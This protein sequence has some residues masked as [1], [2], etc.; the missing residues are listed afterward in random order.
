MVEHLAGTRGSVH[1]ELR[2]E[3]VERLTEMESDTAWKDWPSYH[4]ARWEAYNELN[5][6]RAIGSLDPPEVPYASRFLPSGLAVA[7]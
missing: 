6:L 2:V 5:Y 1:E 4:V 3:L 7:R